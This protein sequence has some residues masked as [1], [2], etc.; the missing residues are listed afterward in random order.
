MLRKKL[1]CAQHLQPLDTFSRLLVGPKC[2]C[3]RGSDL[4]YAGGAY[5]VP[6]D[7]LAGGEGAQLTAALHKNPSPTLSLP[8]RI[9]VLPASGVPQRHGFPEQ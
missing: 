8:S 5:S 9:L 4:N 1:N 6:P 2:I 7:L 3:S